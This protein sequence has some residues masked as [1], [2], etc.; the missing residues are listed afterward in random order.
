MDID[1][2]N[3]PLGRDPDG[4][5]VYLKDIWPEQ[6]EI[7]ETIAGSVD[8]NMFR[9]SYEEVFAGDSRWT[10][11]DVPENSRYQWRDDSTYVQNPPYFEGMGADAGGTEPIKGAR[12]LAKLGDSI[13]T[14]HISP[15]GAI[16]T[17]SPAGKYLRDKG[18]APADFNSYGSR[19]G[20]P[21]G[22]DARRLCQHSTE[23]SISAGNRR[24]LDHTPAFQG[25]DVR[26]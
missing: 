21:R 26:L 14:D 20:E 11:I 23:E 15:A 12:V 16:K 24:R 17:D 1:L 6:A 8:S 18:I 22:N 7:N 9:Q 5:E 2:Q 3:E 10:S 13:T 25:A 19:R 4:N